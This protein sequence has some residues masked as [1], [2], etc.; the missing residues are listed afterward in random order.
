MKSRSKAEPAPYSPV[1]AV[2]TYLI[3]A[4][5]V[6]SGTWRWRFVTTLALF[7]P[8]S[9]PFAVIL[10]LTENDALRANYGIGWAALPA[11]ATGIA[12]VLARF[13]PVEAWVL[14]LASF[15]ATL[16]SAQVENWEPWPLTTPNLLA[17]IVVL[18][19]LGRDRRAWIGAVSWFSYFLAGAYAVWAS[20]AGLF[21]PQ[22]AM[23]PLPNGSLASD[24]LVLGTLLGAL[25]FLIGFTVR[26]WR[27]GRMRVAEEE[28]V[29]EAERHQRRLLEERTR[30][31]RELHDIVAH[32]MSVITVQSSTAEYRLA[33]LSE[34]AKAEFR[35]ISD[36]ARESLAEMRRLL[37]VLRSED[38]AGAR[39]PQPGPEALQGLAEAVERA[40]TPVSLRVGELPEDLPETVALTVFRV[41]QEALSNVVRHAPGAATDAA[42]GF[43]DGRV[44]V[45][46]VNGPAP[47]R[48]ASREPAG[49]EPDSQGLGLVGMRERVALDGGT[50]ETGPTAEGGFRVHAVLPVEDRSSVE[51]SL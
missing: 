6:G 23:A 51:E 31:A 12:V 2:I 45:A 30:I 49:V 19:A 18:F 15:A 1:R 48:P 26:I 8:G 32:H 29:A 34:E 20:N 9:V 17:A 16:L 44:T 4:G 5:P 28:Q 42:I 36:Q 38:E 41:V 3:P 7:G 43:A 27:Q 25:A 10:F 13:R 46:V 50:L 11:A 14:I 24:N 35:S 33:D 21:T 47:T 37:G 22:P 40:G 39:A